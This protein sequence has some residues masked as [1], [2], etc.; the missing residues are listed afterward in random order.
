METLIAFG[1]AV[2]F[3]DAIDLIARRFGAYS[4][5]GIGNDRHRALRPNGL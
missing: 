4:R 2:G 3:L 5:E 1:I